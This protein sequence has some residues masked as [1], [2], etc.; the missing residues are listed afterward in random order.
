MNDWDN[1]AE[2]SNKNPD[3]ESATNAKQDTKVVAHTAAKNNNKTMYLAMGGLMLFV[4]GVFG[5]TK[6]A[7]FLQ[8]Q[9]AE[10]K[11]RRAQVNTETVNKGQ[12]AEREKAKV[13]APQAQP[14]Q[15]EPAQEPV[16]SAE[17]Q[18]ASDELNALS[19]L[20]AK[21][22]PDAGGASRPQTVAAAAPAAPTPSQP[23]R[24][25]ATPAPAAIA[26][27]LQK[28]EQY[29]QMLEARVN[30][31]GLN[32]L[33][34]E[35]ELCKYEPQRSFCSGANKNTGSNSAPRTVQ[36]GVSKT[37]PAV[38]EDTKRVMLFD[39]SKQQVEKPGE[40]VRAPAPATQPASQEAALAGLTILRDRVLYRD[41]DGMTHEVE[42]GG[43]IAG[44][45][46]LE[47]ID[48]ERKAFQAGG[49]VYN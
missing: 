9:E 38:N 35:A 39:T 37:L 22:S 14:G 11:A 6:Y 18:A 31:L 28:R 5:Y 49:R 7:E 24:Q 48:F 43:S 25:S 41:R 21:N 3:A 16:K 23:E 2:T 30:D 8:I 19:Q 27:D 32:K 13:A 45:G 20:K 46:R 29:I 17:A 34:L 47:R 12:D 1:L 36:T 10:Q 44:L 40:S 4:M 26:P 42:L 15:P 33:R